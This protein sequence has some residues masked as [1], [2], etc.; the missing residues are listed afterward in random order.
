MEDIRRFCQNNGYTD[1]IHEEE[2]NIIIKY[3]KGLPFKRNIKKQI[4]KYL[5]EFKSKYKALNN[6][7]KYF[8]QE[9]LH[10]YQWGKL[11]Y[12]NIYIKFRTTN[13]L[14]NFNRRFKNMANMEKET[15]GIL[16]IDNIIEEI[17]S[18]INLL[19]E[20]MKSNPKKISKNKKLGLYVD[21]DIDNEINQVLEE[22]KSNDN[23]ILKKKILKIRLMNI[24]III[25]IKMV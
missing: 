17:T 9:W 5:D 18:H 25:Q 13:Y 12:E 23:N 14:E 2:Y 3:A 16:F 15:K 7:V 4:K 22:L 6:F 8:S 21:F 20:V 24:I 11:S 1:M 10:S 19:E